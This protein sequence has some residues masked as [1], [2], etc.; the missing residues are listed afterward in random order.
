MAKKIKGKAKPLKKKKPSKKKK[1]KIRKPNS[2]F[3]IRSAVSKYCREKYGKP[4]PEKEMRRIYYDVKRRYFPETPLSEILVEIDSILSNKDSNSVPPNTLSF[5]WYEIEN[6]IFRGDGL[7]FRADDTIILD[8]SL[9]DMGIFETAFAELPVIFREV[10]PTFRRRTYEIEA[11]GFAA[12]PMPEFLYNEEASNIEER[13]FEWD[14]V[15][16]FTIPIDFTFT[17][18][19]TSAPKMRRSIPQKGVKADEIRLKELEVESLKAQVERNKQKQEEFD[20]IERM[21]SMGVITKEQFKDYYDDINKK[22]NVGGE[23]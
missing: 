10:Y 15:G 17:D 6:Q 12:S 18:T 1:G 22:F 23:L 9:V 16:N 11:Q 2:Y 8:L 20:R 7:F 13:K 14:L 3:A 19:Y 21:F 5:P 4:C